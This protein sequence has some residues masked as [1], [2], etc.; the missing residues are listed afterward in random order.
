[1]WLPILKPVDFNKNEP[2]WVITDSSQMWISAMYGQGKNWDTC[3]P[4]GF[5]SKKFTSA[6]HNY[7]M[8]EH[9]MQAVLEALMKWEDKHLGRKF[10]VVIDHKGLEYF[11]TQPNLLLRQTR[12]WE[13]LSHFNYDTIHVDG[14]SSRQSVMLL[15]VQYCWGWT[16]NSEFIKADELLNPDGDLAPVQWFVE[17][18][19]NAI[20]WL[21]RL[22]EK[23]PAAWL[24]SQILNETFNNVPVEQEQED[25]DTITHTSANNEKPL[26]TM[27]KKEFN[28]NKTI[29]KFYRQ[30]KIY[31]KILE[32]PKVNMRFGVR[33][34]LIFTKNNLSRDV[35]CISPKAIHKGKWL[36]KIIIDHAHNIIGHYGQFETAQ[37][38][39]R[40][41]W[42]PTM[43]HDI[44][45]YCKTCDICATT[46]DANSKP[47][48]WWSVE[49]Q[50]QSC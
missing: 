15:W 29:M 16:P 20:R 37:Y 30:D 49:G 21:Q 35:I 3:Q 2:V 13:Y 10:T 27:I 14:T 44:E 45:S 7:H 36:I 8:H 5:L 17:I 26:L 40:Y 19:N 9:E 39:R 23:I 32:N 1:M 25:N 18:W 12:W 41:F 31:S 46:K 33:Q 28:I 11:K 47:V 6:Q 43:S 48:T 50:W 34:G 4:A 24:E 38:I 42:W 22:Q